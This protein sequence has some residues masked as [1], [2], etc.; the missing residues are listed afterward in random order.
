MRFFVC[1]S[2]VLQSTA[3]QASGWSD[4]Y[5]QPTVAA[6][7]TSPRF[8]FSSSSSSLPRSSSL[9]LPAKPVLDPSRRPWLAMPGRHGSLQPTHRQRLARWAAMLRTCEKD[10][11]PSRWQPSLPSL[12]SLPMPLQP[13][14]HRTEQSGELGSHPTA[15]S[16]Q[17]TPLKFGS[18]SHRYSTSAAVKAVVEEGDMSSLSPSLLL[19]AV[20][21]DRLVA[22]DTF[23][24]TP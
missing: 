5:L 4:I 11:P 15:H 23:K 20:E 16:E 22:T 1:L 10:G 7:L 9:P 13:L 17:S 2:T 12:P 19:S 21:A 8:L 24:Q 14:G 6:S 18:H 3:Q